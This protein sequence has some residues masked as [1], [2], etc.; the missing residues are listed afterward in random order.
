MM[1]MGKETNENISDEEN[2]TERFLRR[3]AK[4]DISLILIATP[5]PAAHEE[6]ILLV[7]HLICSR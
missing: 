5:L 3:K 6:L 7:E 4:V 1:L 2:A